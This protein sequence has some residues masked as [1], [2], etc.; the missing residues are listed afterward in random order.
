V[1]GD[2]TIWDLPW[3]GGTPKW[4][5]DGILGKLRAAQNSRLFLAPGVLLV[6]LLLGWRKVPRTV[7]LM[8]AAWLAA[9]VLL[10][11]GGNYSSAAWL[12]S[13]PLAL[14]VLWVAACALAA[15]RWM[16]PVQAAVFVGMW[17]LA[18]VVM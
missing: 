1:F 15:P 16:L 18:P 5:D 8:L 6:G 4:V 2:P 13:A 17:F 11:W 3:Q 7:W 14:L 9:F 10:E 12:Q